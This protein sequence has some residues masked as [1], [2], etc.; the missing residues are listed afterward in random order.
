M[1]L[2]SLPTASK[3]EPYDYVMKFNSNNGARKISAS[4]FMNSKLEYSSKTQAGNNP[5]I[6]INS[7][8]QP[9]ANITFAAMTKV[10]RLR[11]FTL[12]IGSLSLSAGKNTIATLSS[13][14]DSPAASTIFYAVGTV[15][16]DN[17]VGAVVRLQI[18][19]SSGEIIVISDQAVTGTLRISFTY[20]AVTE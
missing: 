19:P 18:N 8:N 13:I 17:G 15:G 16:A 9:N 5:P 12:Q 3:V 6:T 4:N 1:E 14:N 11:T 7:T 2:N 20:I 10:N